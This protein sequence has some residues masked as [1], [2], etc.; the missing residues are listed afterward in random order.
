MVQD[1]DYVSQ[2]CEVGAARRVFDF[3]MNNVKQDTQDVTGSPTKIVQDEEKGKAYEVDPNFASPIQCA[4][5][6][7]TN[8]SLVEEGQIH[9]LGDGKTKGSVL[10][11]IFGMCNYF[12]TN[13]TFDFVSNVLANVSSL[14]AGR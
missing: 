1:K 14:Q 13:T 10:E 5:M 11:N 8:L 3:L 6:F 12:K 4:F 2:C 7:L 9:V